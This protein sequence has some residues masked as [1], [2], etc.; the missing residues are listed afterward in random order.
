[1]TSPP[2]VRRVRIVALDNGNASVLLGGLGSDYQ[3]AVI[4]VV[5]TTDGTFVPA[6]YRYEI[7]DSDETS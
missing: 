2:R 7:S 3:S 5:P 1:M 4:V 6:T